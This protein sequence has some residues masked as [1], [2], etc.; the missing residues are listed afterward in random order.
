MEW[1]TYHR[2]LQWYA[3]SLNELKELP[4]FA[5]TT[6]GAVVVEE[7]GVGPEENNM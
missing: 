7:L 3:I 6:L 5:E 4:L 1:K 2:R